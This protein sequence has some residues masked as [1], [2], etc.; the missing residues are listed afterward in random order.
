[1]LYSLCAITYPG[2][3]NYHWPH[4][5]A[6]HFINLFNFHIISILYLSTLHAQLNVYL[7]LREVHSVAVRDKQF[8]IDQLQTTS[9]SL[10]LNL[11]QME[12]KVS[13]FIED[14]LELKK[15]L[16][17]SERASSKLRDELQQKKNKLCDVELK[18]EE[19]DRVIVGLEAELVILDEANTALDAEGKELSCKVRKLKE[20]ISKCEVE[21]EKLQRA[22]QVSGSLPHALLP[23]IVAK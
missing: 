2:I 10:S 18:L 23:C 11:S 1:M 5:L 4:A 3:I 8:V 7:Q 17:E 6:A 20:K 21:V 14:N 16:S 9:S 22:K 13:E 12:E 15:S 19:R